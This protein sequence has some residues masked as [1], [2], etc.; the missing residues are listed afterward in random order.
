MKVKRREDSNSF[1]GPAALSLLTGKH[2]DKC[3][4]EI[5]IFRNVYYGFRRHAVRGMTN[6][7]MRSVLA[8]MGFSIN[9]VFHA[10]IASNFR[11]STTIVGVMRWLKRQPGWNPKKKYL[12]N[13][14]GHYVVMKGIKLFDNKNPNGVF[15]G[16]YNHR[17]IRV[18]QAWE[19]SRKNARPVP[20]ASSRQPVAS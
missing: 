5:H 10:Q 19:V 1:C 20:S 16:K 6:Q 13:V 11:G 18:R 2:V 4:E 12:I 8:R 14:T 9:P 7:E 17:R 15:F 3:V